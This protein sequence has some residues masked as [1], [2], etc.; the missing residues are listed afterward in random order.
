MTNH[1]ETIDRILSIHVRKFVLIPKSIL[2]LNAWLVVL[3]FKATLTARGHIM[4]VG[5]SY[6]FPGFLTPVLTQ[7]FFPKPPT[8]FLTCLCRG[9]RRKYTGNKSR[10]NRGSNSQHQVMSSTRSPL[11]HPGGAYVYMLNNE[12]LRSKGLFSNNVTH[13]CINH[14]LDSIDKYTDINPHSARTDLNLFLWT[15]QIKIRLHRKCGPILDLDSS[16]LCD[17]LVS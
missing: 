8:T 14:G 15:V 11:S 2:C 12:S 3:G 5:D 1:R 6:V 4:A 17:I 7:L 10:L 9:E 16:Q 13:I